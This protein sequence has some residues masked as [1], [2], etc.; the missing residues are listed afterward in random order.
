MN[1]L[2]YHYKIHIK[3]KSI[4]SSKAPFKLKDKINNIIDY[5]GIFKIHYDSH[6]QSDTFGDNDFIQNTYCLLVPTSTQSTI[7]FSFWGIGVGTYRYTIYFS[8]K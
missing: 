7:V 1:I 6:Q 5:K 4:Y 8:F 3:I 2:P